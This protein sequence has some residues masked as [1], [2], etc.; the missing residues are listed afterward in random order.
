MTVAGRTVTAAVR[1][2]H[3]ATL[4]AVDGLEEPELTAS[5][6]PTAPPVSFHLWHVAR[7]ADR[8][9]AHLRRELDGTGDPVPEV[10]VSQGWAQRFGFAHRDLGF[11][12]TGMALAD[13]A[14]ED[15]PVPERDVLLGYARAAF[16]EANQ[17]IKAAGAET[18]R[19]CT[20]LYGSPGT[21]AD[22]LV[23]HL[24]HTSRHLGMIEALIGL[25]G[26]PGSASV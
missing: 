24:S 26:R 17:V 1:W 3:D 19:P 10:W 11:G 4:A 23:A 25:T 14:W 22:V 15:L 9:A 12:D 18:D 13:D 5:R 8:M 7:W 2:T 21:I 20:D 16:G 6:G